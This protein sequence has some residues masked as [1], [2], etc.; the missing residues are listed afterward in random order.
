MAK[1]ARFLQRIDK[2]YL[3]VHITEPVRLMFSAIAT[4]VGG[5]EAQV[6]ERLLDPSLT[7]SQL[8]LLGDRARQFAPL[9]HHSVSP[10]IL[11]G[12]SKINVIPSQ[13][14]VELDGRMLPGFEPGDL[15]GELR[16]MVGKEAEFEVILYDP[17]PGE[18]DMGLFDMLS[19]ILKEAD[20]AGY[21][22]P[23]LTSVVT[24]GRFFA[25]LGI[26]TYGYLPMPLPDDLDFAQTI[27]ASDERIPLNAVEFG[28][29]AIYQVLTRFG[30]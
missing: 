24:D 5:E 8:K 19:G 25:R 23:V 17:C 12:S 11:H 9:L 22:V 28:S 20:P 27:H 4:A 13:V 16:S 6:F 21:P 29:S 26:Q 1:L 14:A 15:I 2:H 3:P 18:P 30:G 10:T 7:N